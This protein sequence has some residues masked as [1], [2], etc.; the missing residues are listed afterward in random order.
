MKKHIIVVDINSEY[1]K[2]VQ[3]HIRQ[4]GFVITKAAAFPAGEI[5]DEEI[6]KQIRRTTL[7][8]RLKGSYVIGVISRKDVA[9]RELRLPST[10]PAELR[11]MA[12]FE[13]RKQIPFAGENTVSDFRVIE[14]DKDNYSRVILSI[15]SK[16]VVERYIRILHN[17]GLK[18]QALLLSTEGIRHWLK[19]LTRDKEYKDRCV[20]VLN[21]DSS[22]AEITVIL[23]G[24]I[25]LTRIA[26]FGASS[27]G[28]DTASRE[29]WTARLL[30]EVKRSIEL[31]NKNRK[32]YP[33]VDK[34]LIT[35]PSV[36][37]K[38]ICQIM[39]NELNIESL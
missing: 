12:S 2:F 38:E 10:D 7:L 5:S 23:Q 1:V 36:I 31:Y 4:K 8:T 16:D 20:C 18:P 28:A 39:Q 13:A 15:A 30:L 14:K 17:S 35:G 6:S 9:V 3:A 19:I 25:L 33:A 24:S 27:F 37:G 26:T 29:K 22:S 21:I 32:H 34:I 11:Q